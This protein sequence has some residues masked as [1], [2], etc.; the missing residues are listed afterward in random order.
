MTM[1]CVRGVSDSIL[2]YEFRYFGQVSFILPE[3][4]QVNA[5]GNLKKLFTC[6]FF[7][8]FSVLVNKIIYRAWNRH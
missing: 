5:V 6:T 7:I 3:Y 2:D 1:L 4:L 8:I